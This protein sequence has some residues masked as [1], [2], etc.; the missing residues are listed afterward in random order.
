MSVRP[1]ILMPFWLQIYRYF[2]IYCLRLVVASEWSSES[3]FF[4]FD[5]FFAK[6]LFINR[7]K[8]S[9][10]YQQ[11]THSKRQDIFHACCFFRMI[12]RSVEGVLMGCFRL[13]FI[14]VGFVNF[15]SR[16]PTTMTTITITI[17]ITTTSTKRKMR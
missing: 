12:L 16:L 14:F 2:Y 7:K 4:M 10:I 3:S 13:F 5:F 9:S 8:V 1:S 6:F 17:T 15:V 11:I